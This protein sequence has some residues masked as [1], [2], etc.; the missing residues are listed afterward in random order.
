M[1]S[2]VYNPIQRPFRLFPQA[3]GGEFGLKDISEKTVSVQAPDGYTFVVVRGGVV[4]SLPVSRAALPVTVSALSLTSTT[5][6][7]K[8]TRCRT[9]PS[10]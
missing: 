10:T 5:K 2:S 3:E 8:V 1:Y 9:W 4:C 6:M 7:L